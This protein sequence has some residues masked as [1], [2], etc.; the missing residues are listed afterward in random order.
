MSSSL[1]KEFFEAMPCEQG[2]RR[3]MQNDGHSA[4]EYL[5]ELLDN[6]VDAKSDRINL[7]IQFG[8]CHGKVKKISISDNGEGMTKNNLKEAVKMGVSVVKIHKRIGH[9]GIGFNSSLYSLGEHVVIYSKKERGTLVKLVMDNTVKRSDFKYYLEEVTDEENDSFKNKVGNNGTMIEISKMSD[10]I[11]KKL[12]NVGKIKE[13]IS[14]I[15]N[16]KKNVSFFLNSEKIK[17]VNPLDSV[18]KKIN[19]QKLINDVFIEGGL[20]SVGKLSEAGIYLYLDNRIINEKPIQKYNLKRQEYNNV[21]IEINISSWK[22]ISESNGMIRINNQKNSF[23][24]FGDLDNKIKE[25]VDALKKKSDTKNQSAGGSGTNLTG[26]KHEKNTSLKKS[27]EKS[28]KYNIEDEKVLTKSGKKLGVIGHQRDFKKV[29]LEKFKVNM[30]DIISS[31]LHPDDFF[32]NDK[33]K[34]LLVVEQKY[35]SGAG[36]VDEKL[37]ASDFKKKQ[38][39]KIMKKLGYSVRLIYVLNSWFEQESKYRD[40]FLYMNEC[41]VEYIISDISIPIKK[42][43]I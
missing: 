4:Y 33:K 41:G 17:Y 15:Y 11:Q 40:Y 26:K 23:E 34:E 3:V 2:N 13:V 31:D 21:R 24:F 22:T 1:K 42:F 43:N 32:L 18:S 20:S 37:L 10:Y 6:S 28:K 14:L 35:Q 5:N 8:S 29:L 16:K 36:S 19:K 27:F 38:Y 7:D 39:E 25:F 12:Y 30:S 9:Y